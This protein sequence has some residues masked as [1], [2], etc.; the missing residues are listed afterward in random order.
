ME[1]ERRPARREPRRVRRRH[2]A[3]S[4]LRSPRAARRAKR[5]RRVPPR[6]GYL[7]RPL[8]MPAKFSRREDPGICGS[9]RP[10]GSS[11]GSSP[12]PGVSGEEE[13]RSRDANAKRPFGGKGWGPWKRSRTRGGNQIDAPA[14]GLVSTA[15]R[16]D[17]PGRRPGRP[18][19][20]VERDGIVGMGRMLLPAPPV[21]VSRAGPEGWPP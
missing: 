21:T 11:P 15:R 5:G 1:G 12:P 3:W 8:P 2:R 13:G 19:R 14:E 16:L 18:A 10:H 6:R 9:R 7:R 4:R 20:S 17:R